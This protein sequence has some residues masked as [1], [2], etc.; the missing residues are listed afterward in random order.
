MKIH[1][2]SPDEAFNSLKSS[3]DRLSQ[4]EAL[5]RLNEFGPNRIDQVR[6]EP[7]VLVFLKEFI[8]FS[9]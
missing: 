8:H 2:F 4:I 1:Q 7:L 3:P 5:R 9:R 6:T